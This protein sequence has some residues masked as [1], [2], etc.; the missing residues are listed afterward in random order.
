M[1]YTKKSIG[2]YQILKPRGASRPSDVHVYDLLFNFTTALYTV[3]V[4]L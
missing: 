3:K 4:L 2:K 1:F